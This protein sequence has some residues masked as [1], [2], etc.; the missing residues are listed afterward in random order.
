MDEV[1]YPS[2][3]QYTTVS[4]QQGYPALTSSYAQPSGEL[5]AGYGYSSAADIGAGYAYAPAPPLQGRGM[6]PYPPPR[7]PVHEPYRKELVRDVRPEMRDDG[8]GRR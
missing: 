2:Q 4:A 5:Y 1:S 3:P 7:T 8:R 6:E